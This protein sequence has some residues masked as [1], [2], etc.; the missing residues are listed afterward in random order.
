MELFGVL[1]GVAVVFG[2]VMC[3]IGDTEL[4]AVWADDPT[5]RPRGPVW[6]QQAGLLAFLCGIVMLIIFFVLYSRQRKSS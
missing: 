5:W 4:R 3:W 1:G 2:I 6:L